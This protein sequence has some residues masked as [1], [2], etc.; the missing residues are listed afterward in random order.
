M[1]SGSPLKPVTVKTALSGG[2]SLAGALAGATVPLAQD[3]L[4]VTVPLFRLGT[5]SLLTV[6]VALLSEFVIVQLPGA[7]PLQLPAGLPL[8]V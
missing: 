5:K 4:T 6:N 3:K 1:Q 8:A 2:V 7:V